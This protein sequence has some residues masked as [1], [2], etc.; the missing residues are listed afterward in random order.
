MAETAYTQSQ[1]KFYISTTPQN[2]DLD[3][4][5]GNGF[6]SLTY[7]E[8]KAVGSLGEIGLN[9]NMV[10]YDT[11]GSLVISK[12][13]GLTDAGNA[14]LEML[15]VPADPGQVAMRAAGAPTNI[16]NYAFK[17]D[18]QDGTTRYFRALVGGP[19][20][21]TGRNEDFDLDVYT[22]AL[23]QSPLDIAPTP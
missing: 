3:D 4:H 17:V 1:N 5:A 9:T 23:N 11:W 2:Q 20:H 16:N 13:K 19:R 12:G 6:P 15:R 14:D 18:L 10:N 7:T 8:V 21:P 22:L